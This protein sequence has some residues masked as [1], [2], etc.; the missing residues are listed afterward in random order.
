MLVI[1]NDLNF[2]IATNIFSVHM[3]DGIIFSSEINTECWSINLRDY[4]PGLFA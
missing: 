1:E 4:S 2:E 3:I